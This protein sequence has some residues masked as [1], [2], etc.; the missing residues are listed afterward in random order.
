MTAPLEDLDALLLKKFYDI[1]RENVDAALGKVVSDEEEVQKGLSTEST[2]KK[3]ERTALDLAYDPSIPNLMLPLLSFNDYQNFLING[4]QWFEKVGATPPSVNEFNQQL[5]QIISQGLDAWSRSLHK[6]EE[7]RKEEENSPLRLAIE[8][9]KDDLRSGKEK[10][11][12]V[13]ASGLIIAASFMGAAGASSAVGG[14]QFHSITDA[15]QQMQA[16]IPSDMRAELG[17]IGAYYAMMA[18]F[19]L[20]IINPALSKLEGSSQAQ[21]TAEADKA[22]RYAMMIL[23][24]VGDPRFHAFLVVRVVGRMQHADQLTPEQKTQLAVIVKVVLLMTALALVYKKET[25]KITSTEIAAYLVP[26]N[27]MKTAPEDV[28]AQLVLM[29]KANLALL[30]AEQQMKVLDGVLAY[31]DTDPKVDDLLD[32]ATV[33]EKILGSSTSTPL[34]VR[35]A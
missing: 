12:M 3:S 22:R 4:K 8:R 24:M 18:A 35:Q 11:G 25:G 14:L 17:L 5:Q 7:Q 19:Q 32:P 20:A 13:A 9:M 15:I 29:I 28:K 6:I 10:S 21:K 2:V 27:I 23:G 30:P 1:Q 26:G 31:F 16:F 34:D 33:F